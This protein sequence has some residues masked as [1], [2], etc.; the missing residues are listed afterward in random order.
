MKTR[1]GSGMDEY[2]DDESANAEEESQVKESASLPQEEEHQEVQAPSG[3][4]ATASDD[5]KSDPF[6][7]GLDDEPLDDSELEDADGMETVDEQLQDP[8]E[9][10]G[11]PATEPANYN[12][13]KEFQHHDDLPLFN[14]FLRVKNDAGKKAPLDFTDTHE[15]L[16]VRLRRYRKDAGLTPDEVYARTH[17]VQDY[18]LNLEEGN[19]GELTGKIYAKRHIATLCQC[20]G[21]DQG[22]KEELQNLLSREY[23]KSGYG[24]RETP[25]PI[26]DTS[27]ESRH[28]SSTII[29]KLPGI[30]IS[31][32]LVVLVVMILLAII[33]PLLSKSHKKTANPRDMAPLVVP[34]E[35]RPH[36]LPIPK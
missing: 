19:Y 15:K 2:W 5:E 6:T 28:G 4:P 36:I 32:L 33:V 30:I 23:D 27:S 10:E 25:L 13:E 16:G 35:H 12:A 9:E 1:T 22:V 29:S 8:P 34:R 24:V 3:T 17:I 18:L 21:L 7:D 26:S 31:F 20:Y 11:S 14:H